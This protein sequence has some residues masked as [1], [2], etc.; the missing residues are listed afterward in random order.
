MRAMTRRLSLVL[1]LAASGTALVAQPAVP[2]T[3]SHHP[4]VPYQSPVSLGAASY[5]KILC[6]GV[7]VSGREEDEV[8]RNSA[9]FLMTAPYQTEPVT[10]DVDRAARRVRVTLKG[11]TRTAAFYGD[12]GCVIHPEG[13]DRVFFTPVPVRTTLPDAAA[14]PWPMGDAADPAP[15]PA[16]LDRA[17]VAAAVDLAFADP[18]GLTAAMVVVHKGRIIGER[19]MPGIT[20]DT[21]LESWSMGKSLTATRS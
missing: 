18:G 16:G 2:P 1:L 15:W 13:Q 14:Q 20:K 19:Y 9:S 17:R 6:S 11:V 10:A 5:A 12:Q 7:F 4:D 8:R 21:Q 3:R